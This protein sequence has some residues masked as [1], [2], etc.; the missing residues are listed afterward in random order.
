MDIL[1]IA[2]NKGANA[3]DYELFRSLPA[4]DINYNFVPGNDSMETMDWVPH[5]FLILPKKD[6]SD[7]G[8][9]QSASPVMV[10][11]GQLE[12]NGSGGTNLHLSS[13]RKGIL[14]FG[15]KHSPPDSVTEFLSAVCDLEHKLNSYGDSDLDKR[16]KIIKEYEVRLKEVINGWSGEIANYKYNLNKIKRVLSLGNI[17]FIALEMSQGELF[18]EK[19]T[20][21]KL[22]GKLINN[23]QAWGIDISQQ[24]MEDLLLYLFG[25]ILYLVA[26]DDPLVN[27]RTLILAD[28]YEFKKESQKTRDEFLEKVREIEKISYFYEIMES[29][30]GFFR[31]IYDANEGPSNE[32]KYYLLELFNGKD[33]ELARKAIDKFIEHF[34]Y[35]T[36]KREEYIIQQ[37]IVLSD[38]VL[39]YIGDRHIKSIAAGLKARNITY[40]IIGSD[41]EKFALPGEINNNNPAAPP[42]AS[43]NNPV[44]IQTTEDKFGDKFFV[45]NLNLDN[46][47]S[48]ALKERLGPLKVK[49][50]LDETAK[51]MIMGIG[52]TGVYISTKQHTRP[53]FMRL[54]SDE[55]IQ[56][57]AKLI[58][59]ILPFLFEQG[60]SYGRTEMRD[61]KLRDEIL[62]LPIALLKGNQ[63]INDGIKVT[64]EILTQDITESYFKASL[65]GLEKNLKIQLNKNTYS[66]LLEAGFLHE[67]GEV[68][69]S[70][71]SEVLSNEWDRV[72]KRQGFFY[73][74][75]EQ[76]ANKNLDPLFSIIPADEVFA[77]K[78]AMF[79]D[80]GSILH[81]M[82]MLSKEEI[83]FFEEAVQHLVNR[84]KRE[85]NVFILHSSASPMILLVEN[86]EHLR[87]KYEG[88]L[89]WRAP[90]SVSSPLGEN[91]EKMGCVPIFQ[92]RLRKTL[93]AVA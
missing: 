27:D 37:L 45:F 51:T 4:R 40:E 90:K 8:H 57:K 47:L 5:L 3:D 41:E 86:E 52:G 87:Q 11:R 82:D 73:G 70:I 88:W 14:L 61:F 25:P 66:K 49:E 56:Q 54:L 38:T 28:S 72:V 30:Y 21:K 77:T 59:D 43:N 20:V 48:T 92:L 81:E 55:Q 17:K 22:K 63:F 76:L 42:V 2:L 19:D 24:G 89:E 44:Y 26:H 10:K 85:E 68:I 13:Q 29:F 35:L 71:I 53:T 62:A 58:H 64:A 80:K 16:Q 46:I 36:V 93:A 32:E 39:L 79:V 83:R 12:G 91:D 74:L 60:L 50:F 65:K 75:Y 7:G 31:K 9:I 84:R 69:Y 33:K 23:F 6:S 67:I 34:E 15:D 18:G 1:P 78:F